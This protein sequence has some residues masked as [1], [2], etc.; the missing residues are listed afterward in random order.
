MTTDDPLYHIT[1]L[2]EARAAAGSGTYTPE[3]FGR[4]GFVHCSYRHQVVATANRIFAG[5]A[6]LVLLEID[7]ARLTCPVVEENLEGGAELFPHVYGPLPMAAVVRVLAFP[8]EVSGWF[9]EPAALGAPEVH[10]AAR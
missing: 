7:R 2:D 3:A 9:A 4:D 1:S 6:D 8:C 5:R 10:R